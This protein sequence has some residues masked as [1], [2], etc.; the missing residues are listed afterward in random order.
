MNKKLVYES[1]RTFSVYGYAMSHGLLLLRSGKSNE[2]P[3]TR[4]DIL[5]RDVRAIETRKWFKGIKIEEV[6]DPRFLDGQAS[7]PADMIEH[8]NRIYALT[9]AEWKG[10]VVAGIVTFTE[11]N[12][13]LFGPSSLVSDP[14]VIRWSVG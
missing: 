13:E 7:N 14:P 12:G 1:D 11:D 3:A 10:F 8:G 9:S 2:N 4:V 5:F 6:D